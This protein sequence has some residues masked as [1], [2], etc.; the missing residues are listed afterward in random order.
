MIRITGRRIRS[1]N[2]KLLHAPW[3]KETASAPGGKLNTESG[4]LLSEGAVP[5][6]PLSTISDHFVTDT[7]FMA[8][9][10][11]GAGDR[12][13]M[14]AFTA[15]DIPPAIERIKE[16]MGGDSTLPLERVVSPLP[17]AASISF[18]FYVFGEK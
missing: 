17:G 13:A 14:V 15:E 2:R 16:G 7:A 9:P 1:L 11:V 8:R 6:V 18:S 5:G 12:A 4:T 3:R 10:V